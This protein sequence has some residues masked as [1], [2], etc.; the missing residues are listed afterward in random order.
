LLFSNRLNWFGLAGLLLVPAVV[1]GCTSVQSGRDQDLARLQGSQ[2]YAYP[3][4]ERVCLERAMFF[5]S[6]RKNRDGLIAVGT[7]VMNRV[8][9][10]R[11]P[12]TICG[13]VGQKNQF[14][15]GVLTRPVNLQ[16]LPDV[17]SAAEAVL[18]GERHP[19][20]RNAMF[21][22]T[23]GLSF[24]YNNMHYVLVAGGNAFYEKR[25]RD[26]SL[27]VPVNDQ[28]YN[29]AYAYRQEYTNPLTAFAH[30]Q[31]PTAQPQP[32]PPAL[33]PV[34]GNEALA[35]FKLPQNVP[36]PRLKADADIKAISYGYRVPPARELNSITALL[37]AQ[38]GQE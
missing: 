26:G 29:V 32:A 21:F 2:A 15:P 35:S 5:E 9:S 25:R 37:L 3:L 23:A 1:S 18:N 13:V 17:Q 8:H 36:A 22:H 31:A 28:S 10:S 34:A 30:L 7:V 11:Y 27:S 38:Q 12:D 6:N 24:P 20:L 14:A 4:S 33:A 16:Q 19:K